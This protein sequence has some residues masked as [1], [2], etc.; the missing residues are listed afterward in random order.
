MIELV[1]KRYIKALMT[2]RDNDSLNAV[3]NELKTIASAFNDEKFVSILTS[4]D[5]AVEN[6]IELIL[7]FLD[8]G[9]AVVVNLVKLLGEKKRL[10]IIPEIVKGLEKELAVLNNSYTGIVY[11]NK[12]LSSADMD[13]LN[14]QFS[15]KFNVNLELSQNVCDYNGIKV[16]IDGLGCEVA[17]SKERL[18]SQ[19]IDH[20]LKAV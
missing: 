13:K 15:K 12:E 20:I 6:K 16:D 8:N 7:S 5:I 3:Y 1:A 4:T 19:M 18:K 17:F 9:S 10:D 11:T 14:G 2:Q